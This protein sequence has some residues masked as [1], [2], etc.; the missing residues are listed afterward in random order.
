MVTPP[1]RV[2]SIINPTGTA[3]TTIKDCN[4]P[5]PPDPILIKIAA[6]APMVM[7]QNTLIL[8]GGSSCPVTQMAM[9]KDI[10]SPVVARKRKI[11]IPP[12]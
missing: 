5:I 11:K 6:T 4:A 2:G 7:A 9:D 10:E 12:T 8:L 3:V 1:H